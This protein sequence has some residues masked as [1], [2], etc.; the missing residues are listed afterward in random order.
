MGFVFNFCF[1]Y[2]V[3]ILIIMISFIILDNDSEMP[4]INSLSQS[5]TTLLP[6]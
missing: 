5:K 2:T 1:I 4:E 6:R 3:L